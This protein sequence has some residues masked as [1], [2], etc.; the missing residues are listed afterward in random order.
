MIDGGQTRA[1]TQ[2]MEWKRLSAMGNPAASDAGMF[3]IVAGTQNAA[4]K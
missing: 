4:R 2:T 1:S 3:S